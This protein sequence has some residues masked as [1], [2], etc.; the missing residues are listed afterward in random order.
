MILYGYGYFATLAQALHVYVE[1][2]SFGPFRFERRV[3]AKRV[4]VQHNRHPPRLFQRSI[5]IHLLPAS[6]F[7]LHGIGSHLDAWPYPMSRPVCSMRGEYLHHAVSN[8]PSLL[9]ERGGQKTN[10]CARPPQP[11]CRFVGYQLAEA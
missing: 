5:C 4:Y 7:A 3:V 6:P 8:T 1:G 11:E 2:I 9:D 10:L